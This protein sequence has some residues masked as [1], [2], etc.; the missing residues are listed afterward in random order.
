[1]GVKKIFGPKKNELN[2]QFRGVICAGHALLLG[3]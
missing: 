2:G 3:W 1:V